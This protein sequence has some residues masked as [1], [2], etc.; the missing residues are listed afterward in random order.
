MRRNER[1]VKFSTKPVAPEEKE[2]EENH[3]SKESEAE[4][5]RK[6][7]TEVNEVLRPK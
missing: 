6:N 4:R 5:E 2:K 1:R 3:A 7:K